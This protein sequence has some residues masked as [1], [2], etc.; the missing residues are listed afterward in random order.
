[1]VTSTTVVTTITM[2]TTMAPATP[3]A[4]A[5]MELE[6]PLDSEISFHASKLRELGIIGVSDLLSSS[7]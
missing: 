1:M 7:Y 2:N 3:P 4:T 6:L 5:A